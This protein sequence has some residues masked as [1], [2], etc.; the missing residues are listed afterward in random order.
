MV[1]KELKAI[2]GQSLF[3]FLLFPF[4]I[5]NS[6][7][8]NGS[9]TAEFNSNQR[10]LIIP[11]YREDKILW[12]KLISLNIDGLIA[13]I[14]PDSG[15]GITKSLFYE[16]V[17]NNLIIF[18]KTPIGY[19]STN[20]GGRNIYAIKNEV[21]RWLVF[22]PN[23]KGFLIDEVSGSINDYQ[24]Y[25]EIF[26]YIKSK[27]DFFIV[28]N[29]GAYPNETYFNIAD[30]IVIYEGDVINLK[31]HICDRYPAKSSI[32]VYS[33]TEM[34]MKNIIKGSSCNYIYITDD[35]L[36]NPYDTLP[37]YIDIEVGIIKN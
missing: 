37:S 23:I 20:Y 11:L 2:F 14:N 28:L 26:S 13:I 1:S 31:K 9:T 19:I 34:D 12:D 17:I 27:G 33:G 25:R 7:L 15:V 16:N 29:V 30:N 3:P 5:L 18:N 4:I 24:Y 21:D 8:E 36:P 22:Y 6:C 10:N 35:N 32:I